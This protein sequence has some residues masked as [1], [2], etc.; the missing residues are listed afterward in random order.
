MWIL[1]KRLFCILFLVQSCAWVAASVTT[2]ELEVY[3]YYWNPYLTDH[4]SNWR[5][6]IQKGGTAV[7]KY[8]QESSN[9]DSQIVEKRSE[10]PPEQLEKLRS[11]IRETQFFGLASRYE[12]ERHSSTIS[13]T[14]YL[15]GRKKE[16]VVEGGSHKKDWPQ[17]K[18]FY[19]FW[20][21]TIKLSPPPDPGFID[22]FENWLSHHKP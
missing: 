8:V 2:P 19:T 18:R 20:I 21:T 15:D 1:S 3:T 5:L 14:V 22:S 10:V 7:L 12:G 16:V 6:H 4:I 11:A 9:S 17:V 13:I